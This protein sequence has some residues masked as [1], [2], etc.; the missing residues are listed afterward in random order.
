MVTQRRFRLP[1][2]A[3]AP[4]LVAI[5]GIVAALGIAVV[6]AQQLRDQ[7]DSAASARAMLLAT[8]LAKR[9]QP[10]SAAD[11]VE[12]IERAARR[13]GAE[14]LLVDRR[15]RIE[16]DGTMSPP[17]AD[18]VVQLLE[19]HHGE[20]STL[21]GRT[22][23]H[24]ADVWSARGQRTLIAFV[25]APDTPFATS[26]L[27]TWIAVF[28]VVLM[29]A[30]TLVA[31]TLARDVQSDVTFMR[32]K[33]AKMVTGGG[34]AGQ[35]IPVRTVDQVGLLGNTFNMMIERFGRG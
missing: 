25:P 7:S 27:T 15:G 34:P 9:M 24:T 16:M 23:F 13:S 8:T 5:T 2:L 22:R 6:G 12:L 21:L 4:A 28:T 19:D 33:I 3:I 30:A 1:F 26:S 11:G 20:T 17:H 31:F 32:E 10:V 18:F 35:T 29:G 14:F